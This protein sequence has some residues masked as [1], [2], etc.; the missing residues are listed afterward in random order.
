MG[1]W[2]PLRKGL[3]TGMQRL[4]QNENVLAKIQD[5]TGGGGGWEMSHL[6]RSKCETFRD[7]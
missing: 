1:L 2:Q 7:I 6:H 3:R 4:Q 5:A